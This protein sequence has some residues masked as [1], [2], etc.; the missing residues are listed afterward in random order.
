MVISLLLCIYTKLKRPN[1]GSIKSCFIQQRLASVG[2][3]HTHQVA[4]V[5]K[6]LNCRSCD[7]VLHDM[8][9][10]KNLKTNQGMV[11]VDKLRMDSTLNKSYKQ[12]L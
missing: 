7:H 10:T 5:G 2:Q 11:C 8:K 1:T 3:P 4:V 12:G 9:R 6:G